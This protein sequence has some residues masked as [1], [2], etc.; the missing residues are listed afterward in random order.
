[1]LSTLYLS[2]GTAAALLMTPIGAMAQSSTQSTAGSGLP[3]YSTQRTGQGTAKRTFTTNT[4]RYQAMLQPAGA[5]VLSP[6]TVNPAPIGQQSYSL[7]FPTL[8]PMPFTGAYRTGAPNAILPPTATSSVDINIVDDGGEITSFGGPGGG[9]GCGGNGCGGGSGGP[10]D[11][12]SGPPPDLPPGWSGVMC[13]GVYAGAIPPGGTVLAF[14]QGAY[15]FAGDAAQQAA[16][17]QEG[18]WLIQNGELDGF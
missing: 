16:L 14:W 13:H 10:G 17:A 12:S 8:A 2:I 4:R 6:S 7:G 5:A 11:G 3:G 18:Q 9:G 15:G 1:M